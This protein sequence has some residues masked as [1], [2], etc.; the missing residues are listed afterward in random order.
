M[1]PR[2]LSANF[3]C[4]GSQAILIIQD[5]IALRRSLTE[6]LLLSTLISNISMPQ[7]NGL[8]KFFAI[9]QHV[10]DNII[11]STKSTG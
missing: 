1:L 4:F 3:E 8:Y 10:Y 5:P 9:E 7:V 11:T 6:G 2:I